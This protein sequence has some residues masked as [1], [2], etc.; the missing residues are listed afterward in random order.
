MKFKRIS[1]LIFFTLVLPAYAYSQDPHVNTKY[2]EE[3]QATRVYTDLLIVSDTPS[4]L[5]R[6]QLAC[7]Y[8]NQQLEKLPGWITVTIFSHARKVLYWGHADRKVFII[9]DGESLRLSTGSYELLK[10]ATKN[11]KDRFVY[12]RDPTQSGHP[13]YEGEDI[14]LKILRGSTGPGYEDTL[15]DDARIRTG[16]DVTGMSL[17]RIIVDVNSEQFLRIAKAQ[18]IG[19]QL[20]KAKIDFTEDQMNVI[21]NFAKRITP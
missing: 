3:W 4:Q 7:R 17:E 20:G 15:P 8:P 5:L 16:E 18:K 14:L 6:V 11:G 13:P 21:R 10:G 1:L 12:A 9:G 2:V 19:F